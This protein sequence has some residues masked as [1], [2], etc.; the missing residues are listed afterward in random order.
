MNGFNLFL[1]CAPLFILHTER[2]VC[3][4]FDGLG[5]VGGGLGWHDGVWGGELGPLAECWCEQVGE[6]FEVTTVVVDEWSR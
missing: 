2:L 1:R 3:G 6:E 5:C 4:D